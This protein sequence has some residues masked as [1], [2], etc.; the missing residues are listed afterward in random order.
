M[1]VIKW[2]KK[3][4]KFDLGIFIGKKFEFLCEFFETRCEENDSK[5]I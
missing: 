2:E 5:S 1:S 3:L 4:Q